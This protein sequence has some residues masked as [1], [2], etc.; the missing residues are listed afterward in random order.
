MKRLYLPFLSTV[1]LS[2]CQLTPTKNEQEVAENT[3]KEESPVVQP[4]F[5]E[6]GS[7]LAQDHCQESY[8]EETTTEV[9]TLPVSIQTETV[10]EAV[11]EVLPADEEDLWLRI[12][13]QLYFEIPDNKRIRAQQRWYLKNP[14]YMKRVANRAS[15]FYHMI[16]EE[17]ERQGMPL[18]FALLPI[19][20]SAFDPFAYSHGRAS[21]VWQFVPG[22]GK[23]FGMKQNWWYDGRR[24]VYAATQGAIA[25]LKYLHKM[26]DGDWLHATAAYNSGEGRVQ[27]AIRKNKAAGKPTDFWSLDLPRETRAYVP[28]LLALADML[29]RSEELEFAWPKI[30]NK[31]QVEIVDIGSQIDLALAADL[32]GL[33]VEE[34]HALNPAFNRWATDPKGP[35]R[36]LLPVD[37]APQFKQ[38]LDEIDDKKRLNWVRHKVKN[39]DSLLKLAKQYH[40]SVDVIR[41]MNDI[42]GNV[43]RAGKYLLIPVA[44]KSL[45]SYSL[46]SDQRLASTQSK[47][48][49]AH[50]LTRTVA[51]GD[52]LWDIS[53][54]YKVNLRSL[55]KWNGM[56]PTD[57]LKPGK[58]L[59][60]W[61]NQVSEQQT[62]NAVMRSLTYTVRNGDSLARIASRFKVQISDIEK[63]NQLNRKKYL[64]PGQKLKIFVDVTRT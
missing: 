64:Q 31:P 27:R 33:T 63:W 59:V 55:A 32:A 21:G 16:V 29:A 34:L 61:V 42:K 30:D 22:T 43:I 28:K 45:D 7:Y 23:R 51:S 14:S 62:S 52:T 57:P 15:P 1:L 38:S 50:K 36:L 25:Y 24:D 54:E 40:T 39:G 47:P 37:K 35:H 46:S 11:V 9:A 13:N 26:F 49:G 6:H 44:L 18:E 5:D 48:R 19:V 12:K 3:V 17:I 58:K 56:A 60:V 4:C 53:R 2:A 41:T 8:D 10:E 20:E